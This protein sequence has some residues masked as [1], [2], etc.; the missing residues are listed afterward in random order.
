MLLHFRIGRG[1]RE[2]C[3]VGQQMSSLQGKQVLIVLIV[4]VT[5]LFCGCCQFLVAYY[6]IEEMYTG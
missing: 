3:R 5:L 2:T 1:I 4:L 6:R